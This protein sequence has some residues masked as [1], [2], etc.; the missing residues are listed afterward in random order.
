[1]QIKKELAER[2]VELPDIYD[3]IAK[4]T[5]QLDNVVEFY[6]AFVQF[7]LGKPHCG[8]C[9]PMIKYIISKYL[10]TSHCIG[11]NSLIITAF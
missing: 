6:N 10:L 4:K 5:K 7:T 1:M 11:L 9:V 2:I 3:S 8:G